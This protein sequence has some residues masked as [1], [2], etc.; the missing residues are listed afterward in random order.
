MVIGSP[1]HAVRRR[2][3]VYPSLYLPLANWRK[4]GSV[5]GEDTELVLDGFTRSASTFAVVAFQLAQNDHVRVGHH[6]HAASHITAAAARHVPT[7]VTVR[8][9]EP[10]ILSASI[11]EPRVTP[12]QWLKTYAAFYERIV[13]FRTAF[14]IA[15]FDQVTSDFGAVTR[16]V[17][18]RFGT[19]FR[20]FEH[21][22][23]NVQLV[24]QLIDERVQPLP[25]SDVLRQFISG[26][27]SADEF[28]E[29]TRPQRTETARSREAV[30][31]LRV[32]RPTPEREAKKEGVR[33]RYRD[34]ALARLRARAEHSY[35]ALLDRA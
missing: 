30:P 18:E 27:V 17:N 9:P 14:V 8:E 10:T 1:R 23:Q 29:A 28:W 22:E 26:F 7:L 19:G 13:P 31:E 21:T 24:F 5:L 4:P 16:S 34:P 15:T 33:A 32:Q 25:W 35:Q 6:L 3:T 12:R 20:E 11:R 2:L